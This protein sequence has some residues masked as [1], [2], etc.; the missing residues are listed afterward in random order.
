MYKKPHRYGKR[1]PVCVLLE[2]IALISSLLFLFGSWM[3][4]KGM[5]K[6][7]DNYDV[8]MS[9]YKKDVDNDALFVSIDDEMI[10]EIENN[11][12]IKE[13]DQHY[14]LSG[15]L[16]D[17]SIIPSYFGKNNITGLVIFTGKVLGV[18]DINVLSLS[19][20]SAY[21]IDVQITDIIAGVHDWLNEDETVLV[22]RV[23]DRTDVDEVEVHAGDEVL[24][25]CQ[26][27]T[28]M[29]ASD[30]IGIYG[31]NTIA[32]YEW[33]S[34]NSKRIPGFWYHDEPYCPSIHKNTLYVLPDDYSD[35][36]KKLFVKGLL[37]EKGLSDVDELIE[38][39][40]H[41]VSLM[42]ISD[43]HHLYAY[44]NE[45][46]FIDEGSDITK[47]DRSKRICLVNK[48]LAKLNGWNVGDDISLSV[49]QDHYNID[50]FISP[51]PGVSDINAKEL[52]FAKEES[53]TI[54]GIYDYDSYNPFS[55]EWDAY[56]YNQIFI[57]IIDEYVDYE[58]DKTPYSYSF[59]VAGEDRDLFI[60]DMNTEEKGYGLYFT[61]SR[62]DEVAL[63]VNELD[64]RSKL[65]IALSLLFLIL[66]TYIYLII[67]YMF[68]RTDFN[69][70]RIHGESFI[71][72]C[73]SF[74]S[75]HLV[76]FAL[77]AVPFLL[78]ARK[79]LNI[80]D[81][82]SFLNLNHLQ[83]YGLILA[84]MAFCLVVQL[85]SITAFANRRDTV[86]K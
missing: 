41:N 2:Y 14:L 40:E 44:Q 47:S 23:I 24:M 77:A 80:L 66:G 4:I 50:G 7:K 86:C 35:N 84:S 85:I 27:S 8:I 3:E 79:L 67:L 17:G 34:N 42:M 29:D 36:E 6:I 32:S 53:F 56:S 51:I 12:L 82:G 30:S 49:T 43:F 60:D 39:S 72:A 19:S 21:Y 48:R 11:P 28:F 65:L 16:N 46:I 73:G 78:S 61:S 76:S 71:K 22:F 26:A 55:D 1:A 31:K 63:I 58:Q 74:F 69:I 54:A 83:Y 62:W 70:R 37:E 10:Q 68:Q 81:S 64:S 33:E 52:N 13:I 38:S 25:I 18:G 75:L 57:P 9:V 15:R 59:I 20:S 5:Q 45:R